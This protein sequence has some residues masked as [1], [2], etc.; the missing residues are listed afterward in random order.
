GESSTGLDLEISTTAALASRG[1]HLG[2]CLY[3][4]C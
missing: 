2:V 4:P 3:D 1:I